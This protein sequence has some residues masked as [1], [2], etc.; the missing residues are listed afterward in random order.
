MK[1]EGLK[2]V[3]TLLFAISLALASTGCVKKNEPVGLE[4]QGTDLPGR[5]HNDGLYTYLLNKHKFSMGDNRPCVDT[6]DIT[7]LREVE[8]GSIYYPY[9]DHIKEELIKDNYFYYEP[10]EYLKIKDY[11]DKKYFSFKYNKRVFKEYNGGLFYLLDCEMIAK[12]N[13]N[14]DNVIIKKGDKLESLTFLFEKQVIGFKQFAT[15]GLSQV[16]S[17]YEIGNIGEGLIEVDGNFLD[18]SLDIKPK[19]MH[20]LLSYANEGIDNT[21]TLKKEITAIIAK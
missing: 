20:D 6:Y 5:I 7:F 11:L 21:K 8:V 17:K 19:E 16:L 15:G 12:K 14:N 9:R 10:S 18:E 13:I 1:K 3:K 4:I 2:E